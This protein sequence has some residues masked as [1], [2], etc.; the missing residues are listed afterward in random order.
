MLPPRSLAAQRLSFWLLTLFRL[1]RRDSL[2][3]RWKTRRSLPC[4]QRLFIEGVATLAALE[5]GDDR[6]PTDGKYLTGLGT[7]QYRI[8]PEK[9]GPI[10]STESDEQ[11]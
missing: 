2:R 6:R 9:S 10:Y 1:V 5:L 11:V 4:A 8:G 7:S 3:C